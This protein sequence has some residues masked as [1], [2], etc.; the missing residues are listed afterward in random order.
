MPLARFRSAW[1]RTL[2]GGALTATAVLGSGCSVPR[3]SSNATFAAGAAPVSAREPALPSKGELALS[4]SDALGLLCR[5]LTDLD[6]DCDRKITIDDASAPIGRGV[7][8]PGWPFTVATGGSGIRIDARH[9]AAQLVQELAR[10]LRDPRADPLVIDLDRVHADPA[11]HLA[12]R[13]RAHYWDALTRRIDADTNSLLKAAADAK[14]GSGSDAA[15][16][17]CPEL[18]ARCPRPAA[19]P[20]SVGPSE[21][22]ELYVYYPGSDP[23]ARAVFERASAPGRIRVLELPD[24]LDAAWLRELTSTGRH[25]LLTLALDASGS[26]RPF[27]VPGGRFNELYGWDSYFMVR[28]LMDDPVHLELAK[29]TLENQA[30]EIERYGKILNANRTYYLTRSQP[31]FFAASLLEVLRGIREPEQRRSFLARLLPAAVREYTSVWNAPPRR[32]AL[33]DGDVCLARYFGEGQGEPPEVEPGHF[34]WFYQ[35]HAISHGHCAAPGSDTDSRPRF[36]ACVSELSRRYRA[37]EL[38]D[39]VIELFFRNDR[40]MR[41][42]GHDT[43]FRWYDGR[44]RCSEFASVD[45]NSL[46]FKYE[47]ALAELLADPSAPRSL[48]NSAPDFC[49][50][51]RRR[52]K[53]VQRYFWDAQRGLFFDYDTVKGRRSQYVAATTLYP[54]W[55][56]A[57]NVCGASL[58]TREMAEA[59]RTAALAE[60]EGPGG[61]LATAPSSLARVKRP[62]VLVRNGSGEFETRALERQWEAPNGWA[63]HQILA[64]EGLRHAGFAADAERLSYRWLYTIVANSA[65]YHGTVP[66]KFDVVARSHAVFAE[67][68]NVGTDF[69]YIAEEGFGWMNASFV[70]GWRSLSPTL[71]AAL[72]KLVPPEQLFPTE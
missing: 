43:T 2:A 65:A 16:E 28:G 50:R 9:Q 56:S 53:L 33:C 51:A 60:L 48:A 52:V 8:E 17:T 12:Y 30:Y 46:L 35:A 18:A 47:L 57:P 59:V 72:G 10:G 3:S 15:V 34:D 45:L 39:D 62:S 61:L 19:A 6:R 26:G 58:V 36:L 13:I 29:S 5:V 11:N 32:L 23:A 37:G 7:P 70:L 49:A 1:S 25:G 54:L 68:G 44:E 24:K 20:A 4:R 22:R 69:A 42:S 31:P 63:P 66:E 14:L 64:V 67:Y 27:V 21:R 55:A 71:R 40:C 38:A 41:E